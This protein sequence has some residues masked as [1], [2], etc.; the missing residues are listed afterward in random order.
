MKVR[1]IIFFFVFLKSV[2]V[3]VGIWKQWLCRSSSFIHSFIFLKTSSLENFLHD[4]KKMVYGT[5][6]LNPKDEAYL[7]DYFLT[8][9]YMVVLVLFKSALKYNFVLIYGS[10]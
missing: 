2:E 1:F 9:I 6:Y 5:S 7:F 8:P 10:V 3:I 4:L